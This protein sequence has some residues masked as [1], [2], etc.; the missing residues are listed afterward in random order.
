MRIAFLCSVPPKIAFPDQTLTLEAPP[1]NC[2]KY[3][4]VRHLEPCPSPSRILDS[5]LSLAPGEPLPKPALLHIAAC[6]LVYLSTRYISHKSP[7]LSRVGLNH[8]GGRPGFVRAAFDPEAYGGKGAT[9]IYLPDY[10]GNRLMQSL[11]NIAT[12]PVAGLTFP[13]FRQG[14]AADV[15]YLTGEATLLFGDE[16]GKYIPRCSVLVR[17]RVQAYVLV[18]GAL[19]LSQR[20][21][22]PVEFSPYD[23]PVRS[24]RSEIAAGS[25][26][27]DE[28]SGTTAALTRFVPHAPELA[29]FH[30]ESS[31]ELRYLPGQHAIIDCGALL[32]GRF[33]EYKHMNPGGEKELNDD[34]VRS[35]TISSAPPARRRLNNVKNRGRPQDGDWNPTRTFSIT[36]RR[37]E[38]GAIT[39]KLYELGSRL[40]L[41]L[42]CEPDA[43]LTLPL[44]G[45]GG[46]FVLPRAVPRMTVQST[47]ANASAE[48]GSGFKKLLWIASGIGITPFLSMLRGIV[49]LAASGPSDA[50]EPEESTNWDVHLVLAS[51]KSEVDTMLSLVLDASIAVP[52]SRTNTNDDP[53][54]AP[55]NV[56]LH[57]HILCSLLPP[58]STCISPTPLSGPTVSGSVSYHAFRLGTDTFTEAR[59]NVPQIEQREVYLCG[60]PAFEKRAAE[61]VARVG[62]AREKIREESFG[63]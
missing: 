59:L 15:L 20:P 45:I 6:D 39:P 36:L 63:Y 56:Q 23:P 2:P 18:Q 1:G 42:A 11:G 49:A 37:V 58:S 51:R 24:L 29:T 34:G 26:G 62:V 14:Q 4:N 27:S 43:R 46:D 31:T 50:E 8:R 28:T 41:A 52:S 48:S 3:I 53:L 17:V 55:P 40:A 16:A 25:T 21:G 30:F 12:D 32:D 22:D 9:A 38:S 7:S 44:L 57:V 10:S 33:A 54:S 60:T 35:W 47:S 61:A 13:L 19:P 5:S